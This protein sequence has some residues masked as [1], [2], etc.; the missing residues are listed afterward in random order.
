[1]SRVKATIPGLVRILSG[2]T[3]GSHQRV[4]LVRADLVDAALDGHLG[5]ILAGDLL[6][7]LQ[8]DDHGLMPGVSDAVVGHL[9]LGV[10]KQLVKDERHSRHVSVL[11]SA[12]PVASL[13]PLPTLSRNPWDLSV[14]ATSW[15]GVSR[16][17]ASTAASYVVPGTGRRGSVQEQTA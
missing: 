1:M 12:G 3:P 6:A 16:L 17:H 2:G 5:T 10:L 11:L 13:R 7:G 4:E 8:A 9:K 14:C 15:P